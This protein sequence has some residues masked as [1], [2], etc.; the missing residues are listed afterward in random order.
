MFEHHST[1]TDLR[2]VLKTLRQGPRCIIDQCLGPETCRSRCTRVRLQTPRCVYFQKKKKEGKEG[3]NWSVMIIPSCC[4]STLLHFSHFSFY[5][6]RLSLSSLRFTRG[7]GASL[8][9]HSWRW[10]EDEEILGNHWLLGLVAEQPLPTV[11]STILVNSIMK[12][13]I[14]ESVLR[15]VQQLHF[16]PF[17]G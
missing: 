9:A 10:N 7:P 8:P 4:P 12:T 5:S 2:A 13:R 1:G 17:Y 11:A 3:R 6:W 16:P 14:I 15:K